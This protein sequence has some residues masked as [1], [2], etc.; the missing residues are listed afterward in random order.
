MSS[1]EVIGTVCVELLKLETTH[2][3]WG[4]MKKF[5]FASTENCVASTEEM[6]RGTVQP[7]GRNFEIGS[8]TIETVDSVS[9][10]DGKSCM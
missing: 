2:G 7:L 10:T 1:L 4:C 3:F 6:T 9:G 8:L 5:N